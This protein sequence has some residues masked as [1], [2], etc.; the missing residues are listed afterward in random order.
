MSKTSSLKRNNLLGLLLIGWIVAVIITGLGVWWI[1]SIASSPISSYN[2]EILPE[3]REARVLTDE[4]LLTKTD[5]YKHKPLS[6]LQVIF[7][8]L[9]FTD[10][11]EQNRFINRHT[12]ST[13]YPFS[14]M[15]VGNLD[16]QNGLDV[17][18]VRKSEVLMFD[19]QGN[20]K[21]SINLQMPT[22]K[23]KLGWIESEIE[24]DNIGKIEIVDIEQDG[25]TEFFGRGRWDGTVLFDANGKVRWRFGENFRDER[26]GRDFDTNKDRYIQDSAIGDL[27]GDG[28][29]EIV[30]G[31]ENDGLR[32][33]DSNGK[34]IWRQEKKDVYKPI[35]IFDADLDGKNE[36]VEYRYVYE[37]NA[38]LLTDKNGE[39]TKEIKFTP[40]QSWRDPVFLL[41]PDGAKRQVLSYKDGKIAVLELDG[42]IALE[43]DAPLSQI[44]LEKPRKMGIPMG[45]QFEI[46]EE[47]I[48]APTG[49]WVR[50]KKDEPK[51]LAVIGYFV[52]FDRAL[53]YVFDQQGKLVYQEILPENCQ[54]IE[55]LP[56][57]NGLEGVLV[58]GKQTIWRYNAK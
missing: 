57:E 33:F 28:Q 24:A 4:N 5:F 53:F 1:Y 58:G 38:F 34:E 50:L 30:V 42:K 7:G 35:E 15:K 41:S 32:A 47:E 51:F 25:T 22:E 54:T 49:A 6:Y 14:S 19:T 26:A 46:N 13:I 18:V 11:R 39:Q 40:A 16:G 10:R 55:V 52:G 2:T 48:T 3:L 12:E 23:V 37:K 31:T 20:V 29:A 9:K 43:A 8:T 45:E 21:K 36:V 27:N 17:A 56:Q 44:K